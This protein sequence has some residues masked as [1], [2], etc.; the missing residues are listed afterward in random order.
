MKIKKIN[1]SLKLRCPYMLRNDGKL[2]ECGNIHPYIKYVYSDT[3]YVSIDKLFNNNFANYDFLTWFYTNSLSISFK[4]D[5]KLFLSSLVHLNLIY[6]NE[7]YLCLFDIDYNN[8]VDNV[9]DVEM[10]FE[11]LND[12]SNNEFTRVRT[13]GLKLGGNNNSIYFR[14]SS[15]GYNWFDKIWQL[16]YN[17]RN[18]ITDVTICNDS[19]SDGKQLIYY[20]H[21]NKIINQLSTEEF[22]NLSDNPIIENYKVIYEDTLHPYHYHVIFQMLKEEYFD[23]HFVKI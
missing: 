14:I 7:D 10:L 9:E 8:Y 17:N 13:S 1:E 23:S 2:L 22:I 16:V 21:G 4:D 15:I 5:V 3:F 11:S 18:F 6:L 20:K 12:K 19:Q